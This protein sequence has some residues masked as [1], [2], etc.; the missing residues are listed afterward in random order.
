[1]DVGLKWKILTANSFWE[2]LRLLIGLKG[3]DLSIQRCI[4]DASCSFSLLLLNNY[5]TMN[6]LFPEYRP[7][8]Q[9][10]QVRMKRFDSCT[11]SFLSKCEFVLP[12][13][14]N[15]LII[16]L[17]KIFLI[18]KIKTNLP[19]FI[20]NVFSASFENSLTIAP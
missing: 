1:M 11:G 17:K 2:I 15:F 12:L 9:S 20:L 8:K 5:W 14:I 19:L 10:L 18:C 6:W 4:N 16:E 13:K 3:A 7:H